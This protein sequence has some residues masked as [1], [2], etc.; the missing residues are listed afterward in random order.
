[1]IATSWYF[2]LLY[3]LYI[4]NLLK[5]VLLKHILLDAKFRRRPLR[6]ASCDDME[7]GKEGFHAPELD[8][9][10]PSHSQE[11]RQY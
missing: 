7:V 10:N 9:P 1:M 5:P 2:S 3:E 11:R 8:A 4:V 6:W